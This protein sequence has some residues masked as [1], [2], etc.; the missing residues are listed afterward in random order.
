M[1]IDQLN[2]A[3]LILF[4]EPYDVRGVTAKIARACRC[5][6]GAVRQWKRRGRVPGIP[7]ELL[8]IKV[9]NRKASE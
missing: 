8:R 7:A 1:D 2:E 3:C 9:L 5:S 4:G 6:R